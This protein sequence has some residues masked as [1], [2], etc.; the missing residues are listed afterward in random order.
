VLRVDL[1]ER[2]LKLGPEILLDL[3]KFIKEAIFILEQLLVHTLEI[4]SLDRIGYGVLPLW[5]DF[6]VLELLFVFIQLFCKALV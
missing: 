2:A 6:L 3:Y 4:I 5:I 1:I